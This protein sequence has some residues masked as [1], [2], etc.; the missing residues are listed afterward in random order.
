MQRAIGILGIAA[1][2][3]VA[4]ASSSDLPWSDDFS[5]S[6]TWQAESDA[7]AEVGVRDGVMRVHVVVPNQLAWAT[8]GKDLADFYLTVEAT[9]VSGPDDNEYGV[10]VRM[11][12]SASFYRFSISGD[13]YYL[14]SKFDDGSP[15]ILG[16]NWAPSEAIQQGR[17]TNV[18]EVVADDPAA[19]SD[20]PAWC[21]M[22][23]HEYVG[24]R[25]APDGVPSY[26]VR[27]LQ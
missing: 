4:C 21:R 27:R 20:V 6:G 19:R 12:D 24:E 2:L 23:G 16:T 9:Q 18:I 10:L 8:A 11:E 22:R 15:E 13:G 5:S 1:V 14:I 3:L 26:Q 25:P 7:T 17:A